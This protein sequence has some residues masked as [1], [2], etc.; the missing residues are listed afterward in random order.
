[1]SVTHPALQ[2]ALPGMMFDKGTIS[3]ALYA[4]AHPD[5]AHDRHALSASDAIGNGRIQP[6]DL[7]FVVAGAGVFLVGIM[8]GMLRHTAIFGWR[9]AAANGLLA[10]ARILA[11][12]QRIRRR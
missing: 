12:R 1:A 6:V 9:E 8:D 11:R 5:M 7:V 3:H 2:P 4:A 10:L